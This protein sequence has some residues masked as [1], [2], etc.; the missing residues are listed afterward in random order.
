MMN[1]N[2]ININSSSLISPPQPSWYYMTATDDWSSSPCRDIR[3]DVWR[4]LSYQFVHS[5]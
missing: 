3:S 1:I 5:K 2:D 4:L